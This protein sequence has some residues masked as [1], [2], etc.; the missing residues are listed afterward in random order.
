MTPMTWRKSSRSSN[1]GNC[2]E[3]G[4]MHD[5]SNWRKS[6]RTGNNGNCVEVGCAHDANWRKSSRSNNNGTCVEAA[7]VTTTVAVRDSKL[8]TT[9]DF[10]VLTMTRTDWTGL[11]ASLR[12]GD[13][14][15]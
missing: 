5:V 8:P 4:C 3:V 15:G 1:N 12:S 13:L 9:G 11:L 14:D 10:P 6:T 2:V 7:A